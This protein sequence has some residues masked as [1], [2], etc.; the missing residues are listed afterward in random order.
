VRAA[1]NDLAGMVARHVT[2]G[3]VARAGVAAVAGVLG[4]TVARSIGPEVITTGSAG[5][6]VDVAWIGVTVAVTCQLVLA[7]LALVVPDSWRATR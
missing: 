6:V 3:P 4:A 1:V 7:G 2:R 5:S